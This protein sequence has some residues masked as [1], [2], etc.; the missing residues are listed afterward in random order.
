MTLNLLPDVLRSIVSDFMVM[1]FLYTLAQPKNKIKGLLFSLNIIII[2]LNVS[3]NIYFYRSGNYTSVA[4]FDVIFMAVLCVASK[5]FFYDTIMQWIFNFI[6]AA[7]FIIAIMI[8]SYIYSRSLPYPVYAN[9]FLRVILFIGLIILFKRYVRPLY[10]QVAEHWSVF[11]LTAFAFGA[12]LVYFVIFSPNIETIIISQKIQL[13]LLI[14][15]M[16]TVYLTIFLSLKE[17]NKEYILREENLHAQSREDLLC[18]QMNAMQERL[19]MIDET[20][21]KNRIASHDRRHLDNTVLELLR[22][23]QI[24]EAVA[25][26]KQTVSVQPVSTKRYC[27]NTTIN[28]AIAY[29]ASAAQ[30][31]NILFKA[32]LDIPEK[33]SV[34]VLELSIIIGNLLENAIHACEKLPDGELRYINFTFLCKGQMIFEIE[35]PYSG[36]LLL[37][38]NGYPTT[39]EKNHGLGIKSILCFVEKHSAHLRYTTENGVFRISVLI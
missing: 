10:R 26:L 9:T 34:D 27:E 32:H 35:N 16:I 17:L 7:N 23:G 21:R 28:A 24:D 31:E 3:S 2:I 4:R 14:F 1:I 29:Y 6:S 15:L 5:P 20:N 25:C 38:N 8:L 19:Q 36:Q 22:L 37:D 33:L 13:V 39:S 11:L 12:N 30:N 18:V